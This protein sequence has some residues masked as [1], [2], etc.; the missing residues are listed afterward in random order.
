[1]TNV[2]FRMTKEI[3]SPM[4]TKGNKG[5]EGKL[6]DENTGLSLILTFSPRE[7]E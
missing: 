2:E 7:K 3:R 6:N 4:F 1:M 5:N